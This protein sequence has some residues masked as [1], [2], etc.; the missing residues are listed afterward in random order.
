MAFTVS[1]TYP[2]LLSYTFIRMELVKLHGFLMAHPSCCTRCTF[3][4]PVL[5]CQA[6]SESSNFCQNCGGK[7]SEK[8]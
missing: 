2:E 5:T 6:D 4:R 7:V 8:V 3:D 1:K